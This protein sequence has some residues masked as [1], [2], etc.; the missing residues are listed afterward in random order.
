MGKI[1]M[2]SIEIPKDAAIFSGKFRPTDFDDF[3]TFSGLMCILCNKVDGIVELP[4]TLTWTDGTVYSGVFPVDKTGSYN[5][6]ERK[7]LWPLGFY[8]THIDIRQQ[9]SGAAPARYEVEMLQCLLDNYDFG[10]EEY[11][12]PD[13]YTPENG[14]EH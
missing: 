9:L 6:R 12:D 11:I 10:T 2:K 3:H 13:T 7:E 8:A 1:K 14:M 4:Y 5:H